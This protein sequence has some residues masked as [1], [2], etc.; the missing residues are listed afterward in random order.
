MLGGFYHNT[1][2]RYNGFYYGKLKLNRVKESMTSSLQDDY[3]KLLPLFTDEEA[4]SGSKGDLDSV[5]IK[6][7]VVTQLHP[8]SKW[9]DDCYLLIGES[10]FYKQDYEDALS[11]FQYIVATFKETGKKKKKSGGKKIKEGDVT[12]P[13]LKSGEGFT[14]QHRPVRNEALLW[15][16]KSYIAMKKYDEAQSIIKVL[17]ADQTFPFDLREEFTLISTQNFLKQDRYADAIVPLKQA[18][19]LTKKKKDKT[20]YTY[21]LSQL[22]QLT[23]NSDKAIESFKKV[24]AMK[25]EYNMEFYANI[26]IAKSFSGNGKTSATEVLSLLEKLARDDKYEEFRDQIYY[27]MA[28]VYLKENNKPLAIKSLNK[29][30]ETS[31]SNTNQKALSFLKLAE[32]DFADKYYVTAGGYYDSTAVFMTKSFEKYDEVNLKKKILDNLVFQINIVS[33]EDSL[34]K[35]ASMP[36]KELNKELDAI[37]DKFEKQQKLDSLQS[38]TIVSSDAKKVEDNNDTKNGWYFYNSA[39]KGSGFNDFKKKWGNRVNED[40]WRRNNKTS[41]E[42]NSAIQNSKSDANS[43][44]SN[45]SK[46]TRDDLKIGIPFKPEEKKTSDF[47]IQNALFAIG[48]IYK[49]DLK[50]FDY[51]IKSYEDLLKR[52]QQFELEPATFYALYL[53]YNN[54]S[55]A[56]QSENYKQQVLKNYPNS[57]FAKLLSNPNYLEEKK[58]GANQVEAYYQSAYALFQQQKYSDVIVK[59]KASDSLFT[60]NP[61]AAKFDLLESFAIAQIQ[62]V[63][64]FKA[65]LKSIIKKYVVGEE[66]EKAKQLLGNID[67]P[68]GSEK[69]DKNVKLPKDSTFQSSASSYS[70]HKTNAHYFVILFT[71]DDPAIKGTVDSLQNFITQN[72]SLNTYKVSTMMLDKKQQMILV[73]QMKSMDDAMTFYADA[74]SQT[75]YDEIE[76]TDF[77]FFVIDDKN[78]ATFFKN[79]NLTDYM[80]FF[81]ANY[82]P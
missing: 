23:N 19:V 51:A 54:K 64:T 50:D 24:I 55:M 6:L 80:Q 67:K 37:I 65:A 73:K 35:L 16:L 46:L 57:E 78:F 58:A 7:S 69:G 12:I 76:S 43:P 72:Y 15:L 53:L 59:T 13:W 82:N 48:G 79:K 1:T 2:A 10:Y 38:N 17:A 41:S 34:Q 30:I 60:K 47:K 20:R 62:P 71:D 4:G 29:S 70:I 3:T 14:L 27:T 61:F 81:D 33:R 22:Y 45:G 25:P 66:V 8:K 9:V 39:T 31:T 74:S 36:E 77:Y 40:N 68:K 28:E 56:M 26:N 75:F 5:I 11:T 21:I 32:L 42:E 63:D 52:Y 18:I 49:E 44:T